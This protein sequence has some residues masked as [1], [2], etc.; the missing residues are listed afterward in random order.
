[1]TARK[2]FLARWETSRLKAPEQLPEL[3]ARELVVIWDCVKE[4][5]DRVTV[6]RHGDT[7]IWREPALFEGYQRFREIVL[8]LREK[9]GERLAD[10]IP[11]ETS[12]LYLYGDK[13]S[14]PEHVQ[15]TLKSLRGGRHAG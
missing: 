12:E 14:A 8:I 6:L 2:Q 11:T 13:L 9:Y 5:D 15:A 4:T 7:V 1:M 10:V 3:D